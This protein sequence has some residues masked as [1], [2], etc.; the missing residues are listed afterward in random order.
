MGLFGGGIGGILGAVGGALNPVAALSTLGSG[1]LD[2]VSAKQ[3][4]V[5]AGRQ[6]GAAEQFSANQA[7]VNREFQ[8]RMSDTAHQREVAD[9]RAAG[10]NPLLSVNAGA[11]SP[12]GSAPSGVAAPVVPE[13]GPAV[14]SAKDAIRMFQ[15]L[16]ESNSRVLKN[17]QDSDTGKSTMYLRDLQSSVADQTARQVQLQNDMMSGSASIMKQHPYLTG[18]MRVLSEHGP[19]LGGAASM[20]D[21]LGE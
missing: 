10:L 13:I 12:S 9:L 4:N 16:K 19:G 17:L 18:W 3:Q 20:L 15:D 6:A 7:Q 21:L 11:S 14:S 2:L 1:A 5:E 8:E